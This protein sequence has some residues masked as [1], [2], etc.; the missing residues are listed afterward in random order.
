MTHTEIMAEI[1][2]ERQHTAK[3]ASIEREQVRH[4][5]AV[6]DKAIGKLDARLK[7]VEEARR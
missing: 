2:R 6:L 4:L 1:Q 5:I 7:A 3:L